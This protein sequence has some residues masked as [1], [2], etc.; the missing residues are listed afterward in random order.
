MQF[1]VKNNKRKLQ[2]AIKKLA[3]GNA[4]IRL[5]PTANCQLPTANCQ[6]PTD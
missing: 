5:L 2:I 3:D 1:A 4:P 6:L